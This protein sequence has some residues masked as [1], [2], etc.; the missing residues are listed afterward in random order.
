MLSI[1]L[2]RIG[3][4]NEVAFR[5]V[6]TDSKNAAKSG[7]FKE[8]LGFYTLKEDKI[9]FKKERI[10]HWLSVGAQPSDTVYNM[11]VSAGII[12]GKKRNVLSKKLPTVK[13]KEIKKK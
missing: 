13:R 3:R 5:V 7:K 8:V 9:E 1:R 11:L 10:S 2:Q 12:E 4:K 6:L